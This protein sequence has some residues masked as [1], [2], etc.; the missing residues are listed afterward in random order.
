LKKKIFLLYT[1]RILFGAGLT[2]NTSLQAHP[3]GNGEFRSGRIALKNITIIEA[4]L[5]HEGRTA[6]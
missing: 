2:L 5:K 3:K 4:V 6:A 1:L